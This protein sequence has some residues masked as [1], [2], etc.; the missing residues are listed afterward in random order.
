MIKALI[1]VIK[2]ELVIITMITVIELTY[3]QNSMEKKILKI[4]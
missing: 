1:I 4:K 3:R 2:E